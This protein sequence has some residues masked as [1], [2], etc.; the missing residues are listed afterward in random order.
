VLN[1]SRRH[2]RTGRPR[3]ARP[4]NTNA[5]KHG[6]QSRAHIERRRALMTLLRQAREAVAKARQAD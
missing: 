3:G 6:R 5:L 1:K 4:G 2:V